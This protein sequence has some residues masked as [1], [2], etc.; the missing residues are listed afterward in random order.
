MTAEERHLKHARVHIKEAV[1][2]VRAA[3]AANPDRGALRG[4]IADLETAD[5]ACEW[6]IERKWES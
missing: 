4:T 5:H 2:Q 6:I 1:I 3:L